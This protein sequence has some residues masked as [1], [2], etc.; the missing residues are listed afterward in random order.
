MRTTLHRR[1]LAE[2]ER[3]TTFA[4]DEAA[5]TTE[6]VIP[7]TLDG[8]DDEGLAA[9]H[10]SAVE[11]FT[12]AYGD[13][14]DLSAEALDALGALTDG[15]ERLAT[16]VTARQ[17]AAAER[18]EAAAALAARAGVGTLADP[19]PSADPAEEADEDDEAKAKAEDED[20]EEAETLAV[21]EAPA[22]PEAVTASGRRGEIRVNLSSLN[23]R[24]RST[25]RRT[26]GGNAVA[27]TGVSTALFAADSAQGMDWNEA[28][29]TLDRRLA[30][31][32]LQQYTAAAR[33]GRGMREQHS[34]AVIRK[35]FAEDQMITSTDREHVD[36]VM[37]RA[38]SEANL[39]GGSLVASGGWCAPS[40]TLYDLLE[41]E[42]RDGLFSLPEVGIARGGISFT[43]GPLWSEIFAGAGF[44]FTEEEDEEGDYDGEG[45]PKPCYRVPC[46]EFEE[47]RLDVAGLCITAGLLQA[48]GYPEVVARTLRG[49]LV[50]HDHKMSAR[51]LARAEAGSTAVTMPTPQVGSTAPLLSAIEMQVEHYRY[52]HRL[53][54]STSLEAVFPFWV[55][56]AI[57][58]DLSRRLGVD[59]LSVPDSRIDGW[60]RE[61]G[62]NPQFV[63]NWQ[64]LTGGA[65]AMTAWPAT[66]KFLLYSAG[67][68]VRG[69]ADVIT[70][71]TI[72]DS[73]GLGTN[74]FTALF[75]EEGWLLAKRGIDSRV[76]TVPLDSS[77]HTAGGIG[78]EHDGTP[79]PIEVAGE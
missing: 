37:S 7:E 72:Y 40:E 55:R 12:A 29:R 23:S 38:A 27:T 43:T 41:M 16:E 65:A 20:G 46:P 18:A 25:A 5:E 47:V 44:S 54:R 75:T 60:F 33:A 61:R 1:S 56:G 48:R 22:E 31:F 69:S 11:A 73:V 13:G 67:T 6:V 35:P 66:V 24:N 51:L 62:I 63:Y 53:G 77:G 26:G 15:I 64:D 8:L 17:A 57:R 3:F 79:T 4:A 9:L 70:L 28:A 21:D 76:V 71:D 2:A 32:N 14:S 49:A 50:A 78:I 68:W 39:P 45:G 36:S 52:V 59:L 42:T 74:D 10:T 30:T 34:L 19:V 58:S